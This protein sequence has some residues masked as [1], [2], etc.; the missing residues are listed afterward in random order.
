MKKLIFFVMIFTGMVNMI[1]AQ[2]GVPAFVANPLIEATIS[3]NNTP[4][5]WGGNSGN[6]I[7]DT[8]TGGIGSYTYQWQRSLDNISWSN[9][10]GATTLTY[11]PGIMTI[12][13]NFYYRRIV[14]NDCGYDTS[15]VLFIQV[16]NQFALGTTTGGTTPI[17][18]GQDAGTLTSPAATGGAPG[19]TYQWQSSLDGTT[20]SDITGATTTTYAIGTL[21]DTTHFRIVAMNTCDT[22]YG[23]VKT[24]IVHPLFVEGIAT[25][26]GST[27]ICPGTDPGNVTATAAI[28]G[29]AGLTAYQWQRSI[30]NVTWSNIIGATAQSYDPGT[31]SVD[32]WYRRMST[33]TCDTTYT[34][35][36]FI[37]VYDPLDGGLITLVGNDTICHSIDPGF[38]SSTASTGGAPGSNYQWQQ[39]IDGS[40]WSNIVGAT[41]QDYDPGI[42]DTTT[43]FRRQVTNTCG[44]VYSNVIIIKVWEELNFGVLG[45]VQYICPGTAPAAY[46]FITLPTGG[47]GNY[48]YQ[49]I[50][51]TT[52]LVGSWT[53]IPGATGT[54]Y[55]PGILTTTTY[56]SVRV[57]NVCGFGYPT[58]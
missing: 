42:L 35:I 15:N 45:H 57:T 20:W 32:T 58:Y 26:V 54:S 21:T 36:I 56:F 17:C 9:I 8:A 55:Q 31:L 49:W 52:N 12:G 6:L 2:S 47:D 27:N 14:H 33:N 3:G 37:D 28:G 1:N 51:S 16:Y 46:S 44:I 53:D 25:L 30:D 13:G 24:I 4:L 34:N 39:S 22:L 38:F 11:T 23:N 48:T 19:I 40:T 10:V 43:V 7:G 50:S 18:F 5:C 29:A 41:T